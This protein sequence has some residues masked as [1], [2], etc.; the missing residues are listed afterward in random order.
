MD[1]SVIRPG[2]SSLAVMVSGSCIEKVYIYTFYARL[3]GKVHDFKAEIYPFLQI[4]QSEEN[5]SLSAL[6]AHKLCTL[7]DHLPPKGARLLLFPSS[8]L[9]T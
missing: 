4:V 7:S 6:P 9:Q 3:G 1:S 2:K 8:L 5:L